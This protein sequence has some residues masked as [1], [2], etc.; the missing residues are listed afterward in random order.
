MPK[1]AE[2]AV[3]TIRRIEPAGS[4]SAGFLT[5][6]AAIFLTPFFQGR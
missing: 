6:F 3:K 1:P 4:N 2:L 5:A